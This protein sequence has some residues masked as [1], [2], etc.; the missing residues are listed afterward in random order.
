MDTF[1]SAME[2]ESAHQSTQNLLLPSQ[3]QS[4]RETKLGVHND[5]L[6]TKLNF[7]KFNL[8]QLMKN[9]TENVPFKPCMRYENYI[10]YETHTPNECAYLQHQKQKNK[11]PTDTSSTEDENTEESNTDYYWRNEKTPKNWKHRSNKSF[12]T[13]DK[14]RER[15]RRNIYEQQTIYTERNPTYTAPNFNVYKW[16][17]GKTS[18]E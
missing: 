18:T 10:N 2:I 3:I 9:L 8:S 17:M 14:R 12:K 6:D 7:E 4:N 5:G 11:T 1:P 16:N 15:Q 13:N